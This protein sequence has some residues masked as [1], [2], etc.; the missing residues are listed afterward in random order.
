MSIRSI[1]FASIGG[2][3]TRVRISTI[4]GRHR[5]T[6]ARDCRHPRSRRQSPPAPKVPLAAASIASGLEIVFRPD[7]AIG[8]GAF[9]NNAWLQEMPKPQSKMTWD[10]AVWISPTSAQHNG[11][12][13]GD[14][15]EIQIQG[16]DS[17]RPSMGA[18]GSRRR[19]HHGPL[20]LWA[21]TRGKDRRQGWVR[22]LRTCYDGRRAPGFGGFADAPAA[23]LSNSP[24]HAAYPDARWR[25]VIHS[26]W[27][28]SPNITSGLNS[29][30]QKTS[31]W[32]TGTQCS[33]CGITTSTSGE[34]PESRF[35]GVRRMQRVHHRV[36]GGKQHSGGG[37]GRDG[38]GPPHELDSR[39]SLL[40]RADGRSANAYFQPVPCMPL[41]KRARASLVC[42]VAC[43]PFHGSGEGLNE[44]VY[45]R[46]VGTRYCSN[47]CPYKVRRFNFLPVFRLGHA[48]F[49]R[50]S[51]PGCYRAQPRSNGKSA[52][53]AC[54]GS[55]RVK[56]DAEKADRAVQD[57]EIVTA[58]QQACPAQA[59]VFGDLNDP[60]LAALRN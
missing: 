20:W 51:Q 25:S 53:T 29:R 40:Q 14:V 42:P 58:C 19:I 44:M 41:R 1:P 10:N 21:D 35:D 23:R 3:S 2:R 31:A 48:E 36:P 24:T 13:T 8:D 54:S 16:P 52:A 57:G 18:A 27:G 5:Y 11:V 56:I 46:C 9:S 50:C 26:A 30:V 28:R 15:V 32:P 4:F 22:R 17:G 6:T 47:N 59:I 39:G 7:P 34:C 33:R 43:N 55:N 60:K 38:Q 37:E 45:N 12:G 49:V